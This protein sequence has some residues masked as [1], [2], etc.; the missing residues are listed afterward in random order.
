MVLLLLPE[1][2]FQNLYSAKETCNSKGEEQRYLNRV[3]KA[4]KNSDIYLDIAVLRCFQNP[5]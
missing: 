3:L 1:P 5:I 4:A 2:C